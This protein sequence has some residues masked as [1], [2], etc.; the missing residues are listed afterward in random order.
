MYA[1]ST[2][3]VLLK[4]QGWQRRY[5]ETKNHFLNYYEDDSDL[6]PKGKI[7]L[8]QTISVGFGKNPLEGR[9]LQED[10]QESRF[11]NFNISL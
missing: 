9:K 2:I 6:S 5:F 1:F 4:V 11:G 8:R 10:G 3:S 7:D